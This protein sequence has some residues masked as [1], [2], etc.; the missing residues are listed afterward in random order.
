VIGSINLP[1]SVFA[2]QIVLG[3]E[4]YYHDRHPRHKLEVDRITEFLRQISNNELQH[5]SAHGILSQE[6]FF[7]KDGSF[8]FKS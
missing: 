6:Y 3:V 7:L 1:V 2:K 8:F 4:G 5:N